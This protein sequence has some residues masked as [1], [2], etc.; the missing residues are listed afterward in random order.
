MVTK[1]LAEA[2]PAGSV[3]RSKRWMMMW[4]I[5]LSS[6]TSC[7]SLDSG[8]V[9]DVLTNKTSACMRRFS[10][11]EVDEECSPSLKCGLSNHGQSKRRDVQHSPRV[12]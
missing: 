4:V 12:V 7:S 1:S 6:P 11:A 5:L 3:A 10:V 2:W 9:K 8:G